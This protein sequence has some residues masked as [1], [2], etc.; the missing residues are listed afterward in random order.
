MNAL[1]VT[2]LKVMACG[3]VAMAVTFVGSYALV[4]STAVVRT[5]ATPT[6]MVVKGTAS[7]LARA[8]ATGLLQ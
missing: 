7:H 1:N 4:A 6:H 2:A 3:V 8:A 5:G